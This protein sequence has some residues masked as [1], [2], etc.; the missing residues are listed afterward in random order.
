MPEDIRQQL[1]GAL[2]K[3][4]EDKSVM[5]QLERIGEFIVF[6]TGQRIR[7]DVKQVQ[8]E[9]RAIVEQLGKMKK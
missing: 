7:D 6:K 5:E 4:M 9:H 2:K 1:E 8:A 3:A